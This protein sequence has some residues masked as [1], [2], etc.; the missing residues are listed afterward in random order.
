MSIKLMLNVAECV[1]MNN[2]TAFS[3]SARN[4][5]NLN[6]LHI[7]KAAL[8]CE[9][10]FTAI[11]YGELTSYE[12]AE[13]KTE[14]NAETA[15]TKSIMKSAYQSIGEIDAVSAFLDP[16]THKTQYLEVN[17]CWNKILIGVDSQTNDCG[18]YARYLS[19]AG[20]YNLANKLNEGNN[21]RNY[22]CAWRLLDWGIAEGCDNPS[23]TTTNNNM[24]N[25][26]DK[27]HYFA[28]KSLQQRDQIGTKINVNRAFKEVIKMFKQSSYECTKNI[29]KNLMHLNL[30]QQVE[31]FCS[32][33]FFEDKNFQI[34]L[35]TLKLPDFSIGSISQPRRRKFRTGFCQQKMEVSR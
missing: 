14:E 19:E 4:L 17:R 5:I 9:A 8:F 25:D 26:F 13:R 22:E 29:Y 24:A 33:R 15:I 3:R 1:R 21:S 12:S 28:L 30:L 35:N 23:T 27:Y 11:L 31:D 20:L 10:Y 7:A 18:E 34:V 32:V 16:I 2:Q 6:N